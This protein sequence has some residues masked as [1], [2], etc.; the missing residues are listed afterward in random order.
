MFATNV[1]II[2]S[3]H[4]NKFYYYMI[5][6]SDSCIKGL[7][8]PFITKQHVIIVNFSLISDYDKLY[9]ALHDTSV[10]NRSLCY[11]WIQLCL[12]AIWT[13]SIFFYIFYFFIFYPCFIT[14]R[15]LTKVMVHKSLRWLSLG[16]HCLLLV[17]PFELVIFACLLS[18]ISLLFFSDLW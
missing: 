17:I 3:K 18:R 1:T 9:D 8:V 16:Y 2:W 6:K 15:P 14:T 7:T 13:A 11:I 10:T 12:C 4:K 5:N